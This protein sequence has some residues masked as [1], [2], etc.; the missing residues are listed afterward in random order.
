MKVNKDFFKRHGEIITNICT[1]LVWSLVCVC[2]IV[3]ML[4]YAS[5]KTIVI[6]DSTSEGALGEQQQELSVEQGRQLKLKLTYQ[7]SNQFSI[8]LPH[9]LKAEG[10]IIENRYREQQLWIY[11][12][13]VEEEDFSDAVIE[14]RT[15]VVEL[16]KMEA[17][18]DGV[19]F[20]LQMQGIYEYRSTLN[21]HQLTIGYYKPQEL[22]DT[23]VVVDAACG[24]SDNGLTMGEIQEKDITLRVVQALQKQFVHENIKVFFTRLEDKELSVEERIQLV[25]DVDADIFI[26]LCLAD[27]T[28]T[29]QYGIGGYYNEQY[30]IP[31]YGNPQVADALTRNVTVA[32]S[33]RAR[34]LFPVPREHILSLLSVPAA[35]VSLGCIGNEKERE[36]LQKDPYL[37][38]LVA[39]LQAAIVEIHEQLKAG[40]E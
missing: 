18:R 21:D 34:G 8:P 36:L 3:G 22:Y 23:V 10:V 26:S 25:K 15:S 1:L 28:D 7:D 12:N 19:V 27:T 33:N 29:V 20:K 16:G 38:K 13:G 32:A 39:G 35:Q 6:A 37:N 17:W 30:V 5:G 2:G 14:G 40:Q 31:G 9:A 24:G 11:L 4:V